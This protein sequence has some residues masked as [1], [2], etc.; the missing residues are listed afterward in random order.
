MEPKGCFKLFFFSIILGSI[1]S[2]IRKEIKLM[3]NSIQCIFQYNSLK[4]HVPNPNWSKHRPNQHITYR[5]D[6]QYRKRRKMGSWGQET[7]RLTET[8]LSQIE[9][10]FNSTK[11]SEIFQIDWDMYLQTLNELKV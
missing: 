6:H 4:V 1:G 11:G 7:V 10:F 8:K 3:N 9:I 5:P 2:N